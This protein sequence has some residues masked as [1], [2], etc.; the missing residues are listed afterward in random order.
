[1][2]K[3]ET[4]YSTYHGQVKRNTKIKYGRGV[5]VYPDGVIQEGYYFHNKWHGPM[6]L[7]DTDGSY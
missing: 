5:T 1:V 6:L 3:I 4:Q 2:D 7:V